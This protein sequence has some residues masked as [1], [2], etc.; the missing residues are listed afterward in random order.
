M[1][2]SGIKDVR[3]ANLYFSRGGAYYK[4]PE[5]SGITY[6]ELRVCIVKC[7]KCG[8]GKTRLYKMKGSFKL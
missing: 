6:S 7:I 3:E 5:C 4:C 2:E 8:S 1:L